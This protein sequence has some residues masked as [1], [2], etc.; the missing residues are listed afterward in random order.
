MTY[1]GK[2]RAG[3]LVIAVNERQPAHRLSAR[4][5]SEGRVTF[6]LPDGGIWLIKAV[7]MIPAAPGTKAD[8]QSFWASSTFDLPEAHAH[9]SAR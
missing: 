4:T 3:A 5:D 2:P 6:T 9:Q 8:W 1:E 7:H